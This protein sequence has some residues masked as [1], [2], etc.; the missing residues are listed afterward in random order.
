MN[1]RIEIT[2]L[3]RARRIKRRGF[4]V[5]ISI[6]DAG[7]TTLTF[8]KDPRPAHLV[9]RFDDIVAPIPG[10]VAPNEMHVRAALAF[11]RAHGGPL[12]VHCQAGVSRSTGIAYA[13]IAD[14]LGP[15]REAEVHRRVLDIQPH[16]VPNLLVVRHAD[17]ILN[18]AGALYRV[19]ENWDRQHPANELRRRAH[20]L[21]Y[22]GD[23]RGAALAA[24]EYERQRRGRVLLAT[25]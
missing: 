7:T 11:A 23:A 1:D 13:I 24:L 9:L 21:V 10:A 12:L 17:E 14:R 5:V 19:L 6:A 8:H 3:A 25:K 18:R 4:D 2:S 16:A 15:G 22:S 20:H